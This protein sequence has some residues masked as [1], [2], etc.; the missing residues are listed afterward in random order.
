MAHFAQMI[1]IWIVTLCRIISYVG[2]DV[3]EEVLPP[4]SR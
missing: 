2:T 1:V 4:S 3:S